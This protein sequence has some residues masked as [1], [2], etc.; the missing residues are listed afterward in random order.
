MSHLILFKTENMVLWASSEMIGSTIGQVCSW[1]SAADQV[2]GV[3][4]NR[5]LN[6][7]WVAA[8]GQH[9]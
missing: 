9:R 5:I 1:F 3:S 8:E 2:S 6:T 7:D 4:K